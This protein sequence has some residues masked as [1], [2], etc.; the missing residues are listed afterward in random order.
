MCV[1]SWSDKIAEY[2]NWVS[3]C[4]QVTLRFT[5]SP[6]GQNILLIFWGNIHHKLKKKKIITLCVRHKFLKKCNII[7]PLWFSLR[8]RTQPQSFQLRTLK[9][10]RDFSCAQFIWIIYWNINLWQV[11]TI[12]CWIIIRIISLLYSDYINDQWLKEKFKITKIH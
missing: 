8:T 7:Q 12:L 2:K 10:I 9:G 3:Y 5:E 1:N 4:F 6:E 11:T